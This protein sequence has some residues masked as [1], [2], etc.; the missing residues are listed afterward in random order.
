MC[1]F[2][3]RMNSWQEALIW[4]EETA[5]LSLKWPMGSVA[6]DSSCESRKPVFRLA[7]FSHV[8]K[9]E[10][11]SESLYPLG[12][13]RIVGV[14]QVFLQA[15][16]RCAMVD[17]A[18]RFLAGTWGRSLFVRNPLQVVRGLVFHSMVR[19]LG[20]PC[21][22]AQVLD[23]VRSSDPMRSHQ[24]APAWWEWAWSSRAGSWAGVENEARIAPA[25]VCPEIP[26]REA[27]DPETSPAER[28]GGAS[29]AFPVAD[30]VS[31]FRRR[32]WK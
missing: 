3:L 29:L 20:F 17:L 12:T 9:E 4:P 2:R 13:C 15:V 19:G 18:T 14:V 26:P 5:R 25:W 22:F 10:R 32:P 21:D 30:R 1:R 7:T 23:G 11:R 6:R 24:D 27:R 28:P 31:E 16:L 8:E